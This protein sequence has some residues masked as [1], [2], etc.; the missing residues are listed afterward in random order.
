MDLLKKG[1]K[2]TREGFFERI[3]SALKGSKLDE[4]TLE[5]VEELLILADVGAETAHEIVEMIKERYREAQDDPL[6]IAKK[7]LT[8]ILEGDATISS[9]E[10]PPLVI[11][12][13]GVN[14]TGKTT[15]IAK[16][17]YLFK[18]QGKDVVFAAADTFR[19]A[20]IEQIKTWGER[21]GATVISQHMGADAGA[22]AYDAVSHAVSKGKDVVIIDTAGR[23]HTKHN[24]MEELKKV[25]RVVSK[26]LPGAPHEV[27]LVID[28]TTGQNGLVQATKFKEAVEVTGIVVTK[29]DGTAK[30]GVVIPIRHKLGIP[31]KFIGFG[32]GMEDLKPFSARDFVEALFD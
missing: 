13:V 20:A 25:H 24:L 28:A 16:L 10:K 8:E 32:E 5:E 22:V 18:S 3:A 4:A 23:L 21:I 6:E 2:K 27:L 9:P 7:V 31:I 29:L 11:S 14:G 30:G 1:L 19:A 12:V 17:G 15:T 26:I